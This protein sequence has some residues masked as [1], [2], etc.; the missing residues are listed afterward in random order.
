MS[1]PNSAGVELNTSL[2]TQQVETIIAPTN[3][4]WLGPEANYQ[5][6]NLSGLTLKAGTTIDFAA[7]STDAAY[8]NVGLAATID[9]VE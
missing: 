3:M 7:T 5:D 4:L 8:D 6:F 2:Y 9:R 1:F